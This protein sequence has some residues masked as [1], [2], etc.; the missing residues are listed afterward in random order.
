MWESVLPPVPEGTHQATRDLYIAEIAQW[1]LVDAVGP[2]D[3]LKNCFV[4]RKCGLRDA[5]KDNLEHLSH[6]LG[7]VHKN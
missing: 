5:I 7:M 2:I 3:A 4:K 1:F 6:D